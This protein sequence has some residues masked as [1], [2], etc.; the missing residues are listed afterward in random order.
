[1]SQEKPLV[2]IIMPAYN[3][4]AYISEAINS[5]IKQ[6]YT[7]WEL[8]VIND[9]STDETEAIVLSYNDDRI[10]YYYQSNL[11]VSAARNKGL[12]ATKGDFFCFLDADDYLT[13]NS[14]TSR[15][16]L[17][18]NNPEAGIVD[19]TVI[20]TTADRNHVLRIHKPSVSGRVVKHMAFMSE[21]VFCMPS[22]MIRKEKEIQYSFD[23]TMTHSE[24]IWFL[25]YVH[26]QSK[27][28]FTYVEEP[29]LYYRRVGGTAMTNL[30]GLGRGYI[31]FLR[32]VRENNILQRVE[33]NQ[34][35][36]KIR[37]IMVLSY[38]RGR[39]IRAAFRFIVASYKT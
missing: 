23:E 39:K 36:Y 15:V 10:K 6:S 20:V 11:G 30:A 22:A 14:I 21:N 32:H 4:A 34:L 5:V 18:Q 16:K 33:L 28:E 27:L 2:S 7:N 29:I 1:M 3:A 13:P 24:D 26:N 8:L 12:M 37:R 17:F 38:L 31:Q 19:G 9:G 25:L 35:R